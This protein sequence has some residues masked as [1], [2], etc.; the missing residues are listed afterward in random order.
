M[1]IPRLIPQKYKYS[2]ILPVQFNSKLNE[3]VDYCVVNFGKKSKKWSYR[4]NYYYSLYQPRS[5]F[6]FTNR[7]CYIQFMLTWADGI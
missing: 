3:M 6:Y 7:S 2:I 1:T 5:C 4:V